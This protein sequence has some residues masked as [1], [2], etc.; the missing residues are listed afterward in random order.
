MAVG[1]QS[2]GES[3]RPQ[4]PRGKRPVEPSSENG[5]RFGLRYVP[6]TIPG[7]DWDRNRLP[8]GFGN[9]ASKQPDMLP[10][11]QPSPRRGERFDEQA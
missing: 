6:S 5:D 2:D 9:G 11:S 1:L 4:L 7:R 10:A 3:P 8:Q